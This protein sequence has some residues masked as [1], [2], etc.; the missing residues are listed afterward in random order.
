MWKEIYLCNS[1]PSNCAYLHTLRY[2]PLNWGETI[3][4]FTFLSQRIEAM[5]MVGKKVCYFITSLFSP[6]LFLCF[7]GVFQ[8]RFSNQEQ[9]MMMCIR[10]IQRQISCEIDECDFRNNFTPLCTTF[11]IVHD[12][13]CLDLFCKGQFVLNFSGGMPLSDSLSTFFDSNCYCMTVLHVLSITYQIDEHAST[14]Y[15]IA[16]RAK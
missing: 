15:L 4:E 1:S 14:G 3:Y 12:M 11:D 13:T 2:C 10:Q 7:Q 9:V 8:E 16:K 5:T 6:F